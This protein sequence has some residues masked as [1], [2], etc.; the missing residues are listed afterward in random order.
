MFHPLA[1]KGKFELEFRGTLAALLRIGGPRQA[2]PP[3]RLPAGVL[4]LISLGK[5][6]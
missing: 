6:R 4:I 1:Q 2:K 5:V 3:R